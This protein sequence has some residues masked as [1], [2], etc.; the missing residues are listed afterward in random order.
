MKTI[1][2]LAYLPFKT[3]TLIYI[4]LIITLQI[5]VACTRKKFGGKYFVTH[6]VMESV[7]KFWTSLLKNISNSRYLVV[8]LNQD[9]RFNRYYFLER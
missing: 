9:E 7:D 4:V 2:K 3:L 6:S 5:E 1:I 8:K